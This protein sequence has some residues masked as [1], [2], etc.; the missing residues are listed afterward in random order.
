MMASTH[1]L[2]QLKQGENDNHKGIYRFY[3]K[4]KMNTK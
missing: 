3:L 2:M 1:S 4:I